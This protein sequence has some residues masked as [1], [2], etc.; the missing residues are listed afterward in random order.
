MVQLRRDSALLLMFLW[1]RRFCRF[2]HGQ[3]NSKRRAFFGLAF[4]FDEAVVVFDNAVDDRQTETGSFAYAFSCVERLEHAGTHF[5][6]N[7][8]SRIV[9]RNT[10]VGSRCR[11]DVLAL[12][13]F[14]R[15]NFFRLNRELA[16]RRHRVAG[17]E[18]NIEQ[19]L[20]HLIAIRQDRH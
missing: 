19:H 11:L 13:H 2:Q 4:G 5:F 12:V 7:S 15:V 6:C 20:T 10:D 1:H 3:V 17:I 16:A 18:A 8:D 14:H 9:D